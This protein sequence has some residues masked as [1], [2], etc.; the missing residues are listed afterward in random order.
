MDGRGRVCFWPTTTDHRGLQLAG[1][2]C[3]APPCPGD[4]ASVCSP[5]PSQLR[6]CSWRWRRPGRPENCGRPSASRCIQSGRRRVLSVCVQCFESWQNYFKVIISE[7]IDEKR[8]QILMIYLL[9][10]I[11]I[12]VVLLLL[13]AQVPPHPSD[14]LSDLPQLQVGVGRLHLVPYLVKHT[15]GQRHATHV[16]RQVCTPNTQS[17]KKKKKSN[18][19]SIRVVWSSRYDWL[20]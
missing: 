17:K 18:T 20:K 10:F 13:V 5:P 3:R 7:T 2:S 19:W 16:H 14:D 11:L 9:G 12:Q 6:P 4:F 15:H 1:C 8:R